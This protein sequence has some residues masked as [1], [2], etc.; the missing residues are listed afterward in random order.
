MTVVFES[1]KKNRQRQRVR[2]VRVERCEWFWR[3]EFFGILPR[4]TTLRGCDFFITSRKGCRH[5]KQNT[6]VLRFAQNDKQKVTGSQGQDDSR[7][8]QQQQQPQI[9]DG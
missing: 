3:V 2:K 8:R 6:G 4:S 5:C 1:W 9:P 7:N